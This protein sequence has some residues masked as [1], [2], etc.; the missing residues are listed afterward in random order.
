M[1]DFIPLEKLR[2]MLPIDEV[3]FFSLLFSA[4]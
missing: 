4:Y 3:L 2:Q 1:S